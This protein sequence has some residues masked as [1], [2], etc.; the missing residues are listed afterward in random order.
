MGINFN[1]VIPGLYIGNVRSRNYDSSPEK[2][3]T[4]ISV[5]VYDMGKPK[6]AS[7]YYFF[8][9]LDR[10]DVSYEV[11]HSVVFSAAEVIDRCI[12]RG[13][14]VHCGVGVSRSALVVIGYLM[15]N[16][17]MP[18]S[19]AYALLQSKRPC[20]NPNDGFVEFLKTLDAQLANERQIFLA[21]QLA[22]ADVSYDDL[23]ICDYKAML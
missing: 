9:L 11:M 14:L 12:S 8:K 15:I 18:L 17:H 10:R 7:N 5:G 2:C 23:N 6:W 22:K 20:V 1:E 3:M 19:D 13:V 21:S 4:C 16:K